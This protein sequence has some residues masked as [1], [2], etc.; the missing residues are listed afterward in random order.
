MAEV[1][2]QIEIPANKDLGPQLTVGRKFFLQCDGDWPA[3]NQGN[4]ELRLPDTDKYKLQL[5]GFEFSSK[6]QGKLVVVS[7]KAGSHQLQ[8]VQ[9]MDG[10]N[11]VTLK[12]LSFEVQT[13]IEQKETPAEPYGPLGAIQLRLSL[14]YW[15]SLGIL[16][17]AAGLWIYHF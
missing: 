12:P 14:I 3:L 7:Y 1:Q 4:L 5:L 8:N 11:I 2:C 6:T 17:L 10:Q 9:L 13:V 16:L 15:L